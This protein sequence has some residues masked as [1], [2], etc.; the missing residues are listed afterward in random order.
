LVRQ[1]GASVR[2]TS[3]ETD[4]TSRIT[5]GNGS[6]NGVLGFSSGTIALRVTVLAKVAAAAL[7][8]HRNTVSFAN[9]MFD[10]SSGSPFAVVALATTVVDEAGQEYLYM[11]DA[12]TSTVNLG[13]SSTI[14]VQD[15]FQGIANALRFDTGLEATSGD[16]GVGEAAFGGFFV[17]SNKTNG[18]GSINTSVLNNGA[19]QDGVVG[20]TYRDAVT[21]L[22]FTI[23]PR[24]WSTNHNGPWIAYP[25]GSNATFRINVSKTFTTNGNI[26]HQAVPGIELKVANTSGVLTGDTGK[27]QTFQRGGNE[28]AI[29]D[30]YYVSYYYSKENFTTGFFTKMKTI[31][32]VYGPAT[33]DNPVSLAAYLAILNGAVL[34][35]IKQVPREPGQS[36]ASINTYRDAITELEGVLPGQVKPD[37]IVPLRGDSVSLYQILA[38]S[39]NIQS[40]LRYRNER[41]AIA[42]VAAGTTPEQAGSMAL[43]L[44]NTRFRLLY[45]DE[46]VITFSNQDGST[47]EEIVD[48]TYLAAAL[49]GSVVSPNVD[50][51]TPWTGRRLVGFTQLARQ[52]DAVQQNQTAVKGVTI[53]EDRPPYL[54]I[55]HGLTTD[56]TGITTDGN[57]TFSKMPT[58]I[59]IADEVQQQSR[60]VLEQFIGIK[61]LPGVLSQIEGRLSM[62]LKGLVAAQIITAYTGVKATPSTDDPSTVNC[63]AYFSPVVGLDY[64][65]VQFNLRSSL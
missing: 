44:M 42:G 1:E 21:G 55:R 36:Q 30:L 10:V 61:F 20:Q 8:A 19:G 3:M 65:M 60:N 22:T 28:P 52:L 16:G 59:Q 64:I 37:I 11:Q 35:G 4:T 23:L 46:V 62:M 24:G 63:V 33:S 25:T 34:V 17:V 13:A 45:P 54:R 27:V 48:G 51:A 39:C 26:P 9:W 58:I 7:M 56:S 14:A 31:E 38:R 12:P 40:S 50:V 43:T 6:A 15:T 32:Q 2:I 49:A 41:T 53:L 5:I 29:G 47:R 57:V 18:S